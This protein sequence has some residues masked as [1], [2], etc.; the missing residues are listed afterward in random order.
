MIFI[1]KQQ[2]TSSNPVWQMFGHNSLNLVMVR[3]EEPTTSIHVHKRRY[4]YRIEITSHACTCIKVLSLQLFSQG[5][6]PKKIIFKKRKLQI[7]ILKVSTTVQKDR[8]EFILSNEEAAT[9]ELSS[10]CCKYVF[11]YLRVNSSAL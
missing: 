4:I 2:L 1:V 7:M 9:K 5:F 6:S 3:E 11:L 8:K 10:V